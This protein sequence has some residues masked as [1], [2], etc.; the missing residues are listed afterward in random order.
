MRN[1]DPVRP[2]G[3]GDEA[4]DIILRAAGPLFG[5]QRDAFLE[6]VAVA[7]RVIRN[8]GPGTVYQVVREI[9]KRHWDPPLRTIG[10]LRARG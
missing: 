7:L 9:Q 2:F 1:P 4:G 8:P 3:V 5:P 10:G 6:E